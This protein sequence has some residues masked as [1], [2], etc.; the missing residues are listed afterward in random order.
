VP[1]LDRRCFPAMNLRHISSLPAERPRA[2]AKSL[3]KSLID[4]L[5]GYG[6]LMR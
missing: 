2:R 4:L 1:D 6:N 5:H 3:P